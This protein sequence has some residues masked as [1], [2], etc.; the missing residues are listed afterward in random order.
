V[1]KKKRRLCPT[2]NVEREIVMQTTVAASVRE[3]IQ[4]KCAALLVYKQPR[5]VV[6]KN[7]FAVLRSLPKEGAE[8]RGETPA[9]D[10]NLDRQTN[11]HCSNL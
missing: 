4:K 5:P 6:T 2:E 1:S 11:P 10:N 8:V 7:F 9:S 3:R